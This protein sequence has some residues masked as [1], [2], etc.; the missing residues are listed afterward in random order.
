MPGKHDTPIRDRFLRVGTS[1]V[2]DALDE[3]GYSNQ[4]LSADLQ[5][6]AGDQVAGWAYTISGEPAE[7]QGSGDPKKMAACNGVGPDEVSVWSGGGGDGVCYFGELIALAM[8]E[9]GC[10]GA[11]VDGGVRDVAWLRHHEFP[12]FAG[13]RTP[14]QSIGRWRVTGWQQPVTMPGA[15]A[16]SVTV[17]PGDFILGDHDGVI[18]VPRGSVLDVLAR[19]ESLT[20]TEVKIREALA[21]GQS[22]SECLATFGH[23]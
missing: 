3:L 9:R 10:R 5:S 2:A 14:I 7:Y 15:T 18:A 21:S 20:E 17:S 13:F 1:N 23:V 12:V 16:S 6:L 22:L 4:G 11:I 19:A 8:Q